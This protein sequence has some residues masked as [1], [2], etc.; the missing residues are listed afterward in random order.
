MTRIRSEL[1]KNKE[2]LTMTRK[3]R[4]SRPDTLK[5]ATFG[6]SNPEKIPIGAMESR[7][8]AISTRSDVW[9]LTPRTGPTGR[10]QLSLFSATLITRC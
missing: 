3:S 5:S 6:S 1:M 4:I 8:A 2:L 9:S 10:T 7:C